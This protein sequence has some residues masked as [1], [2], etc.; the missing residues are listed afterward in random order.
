MNIIIYRVSYICMNLLNIIVFTVIIQWYVYLNWN[1][2]L[3]ATEINTCNFNINMPLAQSR[4]MVYQKSR[5]KA[6][7]IAK[8]EIKYMGLLVGYGTLEVRAPIKINGAWYRNFYAEGKTGD[9]YKLIFMAH[10]KVSAI[11]NP[12]NYGVVKF[13]IDQNEEKMFSK[14]FVQKKWFNFDHDKCRVREKILK[15]NKKEKIEEFFIERGVSDT[16]GI[17]YWLREQ[18]FEINKPIK[19]LVYSSTKNWM[20]EVIPLSFEKIK[21]NAGEFE[22]AKLKFKTYLGKELQQKGEAYAW[23][24]IKTPYRPIVLIKGEIKIGNVWISLFDFKPGHP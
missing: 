20:L 14:K 4:D 9:W 21:V 16:L 8:Y 18:N 15:D 5:Y 13:F 1:L 23:I 11:V 12:L 22:T 10:D 24:D 7:E 3:M 19:K 2:T 6:G 17:T